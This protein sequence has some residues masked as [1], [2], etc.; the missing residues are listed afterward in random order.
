MKE[1][2]VKARAFAMPLTSPAYPPGPYRFVNREFL[3]IT[4]RTDPEKLRAR[5]A[6]AARDRRADGQVRVH[7]HAGFHRLR[8]LHRDRA[9]HPGQVSGPQG[10]LHPLHVPQRRA[11]DRRRP[12]ALGLSEEAREPD[13]A[14]RDR[15]IGRHARLWPGPRRHRHHGIQA[16]VR[17]PGRGPRL[18]R[19]PEL[20]AQDHS[21][22]RRHAR[23]SASW[24]NTTSRTSR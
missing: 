15:H 7:P 16:Q 18:A 8:R 21:A 1:A 9:G 11:A 23:V 19:G 13:A 17:R 6:R 20:P 10:R 3:V 14:S 22:R 4:Y 12:R 5:G 24:S 2:E